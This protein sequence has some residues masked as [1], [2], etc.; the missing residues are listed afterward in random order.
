MQNGVV[1]LLSIAFSFVFSFWPF[2]LLS[3]LARLSGR[4]FSRF[5]IVALNVWIVVAVMR[6]FMWFTS[7]PT[8]L[9]V[10]IKEPANTIWF[11]VVGLVLIV[12]RVGYSYWKPDI[13][14]RTSR[15]SH[16]KKSKPSISSEQYR[17][18]NIIVLL[19]RMDD[20]LLRSDYAG[21]LHA[22]ASVFETV[23]KEV[24]GIPTVQD[25]TLKQFFDRYKNDSSLPPE[26]LNYIKSV[27]EKRNTTPLAG[28]GSIQ[29]PALSKRDAIV[30]SELTKAFVN[31]E[32]KSR[33]DS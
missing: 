22:S 6:A 28:H 5:F 27:Y 32:Y 7:T 10:F 1:Q 15:K 14:T 21:V 26:I 23:A 13:A 11:F 2:V 12:L 19:G 24:V 9:E 18:P 30:L 20:A 4:N 17:H 33:R 3:A 31:I 25:K 16:L 8:L 29:I